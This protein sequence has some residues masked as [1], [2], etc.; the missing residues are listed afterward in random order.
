MW[1]AAGSALGDMNEK[2]TGGESY[3]FFQEVI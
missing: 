3:S 1:R 2:L